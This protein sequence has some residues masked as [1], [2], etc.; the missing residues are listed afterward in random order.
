MASFSVLATQGTMPVPAIV[1][2]S[3]L[4]QAVTYFPYAV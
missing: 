1:H 4:L 3:A 2:L